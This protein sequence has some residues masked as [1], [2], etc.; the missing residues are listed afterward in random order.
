[1]YSQNI[2]HFGPWYLSFPKPP[3]LSD[4]VVRKFLGIKI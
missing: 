4:E 3:S 1:M 2:V